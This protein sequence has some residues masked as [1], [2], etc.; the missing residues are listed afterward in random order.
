MFFNLDTETL[1]IV[2]K[3]MNGAYLRNDRIQNNVANIDTPGYVFSDIKFNDYLSSLSVRPAS[4][5]IAL[6]RT[7]NVHFPETAPDP[8]SKLP[9]I[10]YEQTTLEQEMVNLMK[11]SVFFNTMVSFHSSTTKGIRSAIFEGR[12]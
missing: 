8:G 4:P 10:T 3:A 11:N 12:R 9:L 5:P 1:G 7:N 6:S 2:N